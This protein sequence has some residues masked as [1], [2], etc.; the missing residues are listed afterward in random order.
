MKIKMIILLLVFSLSA[1]AQQGYVVNGKPSAQAEPSYEE[2]SGFW[3]S[4]IFNQTDEINAAEICGGADKIA[5]VDARDS[6]KNILISIV[7]LGIYTP[8]SKRVYCVE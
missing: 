8:R 3:F 1:C 7:T 4:G 2:N 6:G 5:Y